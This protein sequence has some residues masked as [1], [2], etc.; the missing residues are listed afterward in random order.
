MDHEPVKIQIL[1]NDVPCGRLES[2]A[3]HHTPAFLVAVT[4]KLLTKLQQHQSCYGYASIPY[5]RTQLH[6]Y[7]HWYLEY[8]HIVMYVG[9][10]VLSL[11]RHLVELALDRMA[12]FQGLRVIALRTTIARELFDG[13]GRL[14]QNTCVT[15]RLSI[16]A[17]IDFAPTVID[18]IVAL[19]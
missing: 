18:Y 9:A 8:V 7:V 19:A 11:N 3:R 15:N 1:S 17:S 16:H 12:V 6:C 5:V 4:A 13:G 2:R 10:R 14:N